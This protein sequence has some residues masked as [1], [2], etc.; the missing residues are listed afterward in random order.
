MLRIKLG[1]GRRE[2]RLL[3]HNRFR[4][5]FDLHPREARMLGVRSMLAESDI[6]KLALAPAAQ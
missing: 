5:H 6:V 1:D 3:A 4:L 2:E